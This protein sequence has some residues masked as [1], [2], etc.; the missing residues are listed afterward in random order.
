MTKRRPFGIPRILIFIVAIAV[1]WPLLKGLDTIIPMGA[2]SPLIALSSVVSAPMLRWAVAIGLVLLLFAILRRRFFC[3]H[4]CPVGVLQQACREPWHRR[5]ATGVRLALPWPLG[6]WLF[7]MTLGGALVGYP[8]FLW[9]DPLSLLSAAFNAW[10]GPMTVCAF[11]AGMALPAILILEMF[12]PRLWCMRICP[13]GGMQDW[14][15]SASRHVGRSFSTSRADLAGGSLLR[16]TFLGVGIG[17]AW[18]LVARSA[19]AGTGIAVRPP[20]AAN[21]DQFTALCIRCGSCIRCCP[22]QILHHDVLGHGLAGL[23]TPA[24]SFDSGYCREHCKRCTEVCP[25]GAI[26][27]MTIGEK[28]RVVMGIVRIDIETCALATGGECTACITQCPYEALS[29]GQSPDGFASQPQL[30]ADRC[31][32]CGACEAVCPVRP[33]RAIRIFA[34]AGGSQ[35]RLPIA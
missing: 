7:L 13:L 12:Q 25:S 35:G 34:P 23:L 33:T 20:G 15:F 4:V 10:R 18:G 22:P 27:R 11:V 6:S 31:T 8:L 29:I 1:A 5:R 9:L 2:V 30:D 17:A 19:K 21:E 14:A 16:R 32:G 24:A 28:R 26:S 3:R